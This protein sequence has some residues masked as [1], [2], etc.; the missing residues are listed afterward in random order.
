GFFGNLL[1]VG[2]ITP[3]F[4]TV[5][6]YS[7]QIAIDGD[8]SSSFVLSNGG[9]ALA[10]VT[11]VVAIT[12]AGSTDPNDTVEFSRVVTVQPGGGTFSVNVS[13]ADLNAAGIGAGLYSVAFVA[14]DAGSNSI[15]EF[16][17]NLLSIGTIAPTFTQAPTF[18]GTIDENSAFTASF[19]LGNTGN[20]PANGVSL[21][22]AITPV[23]STDPNDSKEFER[24]VTVPAGGGVFPVTIG[25]A[26]LD[27]AGI[28]AGTYTLAFVAVD[29]SGTR[30]GE[31]FGNIL[32]IGQSAVGIAQLPAYA[33]QIDQGSP[34]GATWTLTNSGSVSGDATLLTVIT[35]AGSTDPNDAV[36]FY[37]TATIPAGG[38]SVTVAITPAELA[39]A[40]I[41]AG[42]YTVAFIL[43]DAQDQR[44]GEFF[45]NLLEIF[46][47]GGSQTAV[48]F[49]AAQQAASG[50]AA[51]L[52]DAWEVSSGHP[53]EAGLA[54][55]AFIYDQAVAVFAL[56]L[57]G[58]A[59]DEA[60]ARSILQGLADLENGTGR[61]GF[62]YASG[63][64]GVEV[65]AVYSGSLAWVGYAAALYDLMTGDN[66]FR[67]M[68]IRIADQL[69]GFM[70]PTTGLI[71]GGLNENGN[72]FP[73]A[74]TEHNVD[75]YLFLSELA[76][77]TGEARFRD[78]AQTVALGILTHLWTGEHFFQGYQDDLI[79]LDAQAL[80]GLFLVMINELDDAQVVRDFIDTRF[81]RTVNVSGTPVTGYAPYQD[82]VFD[83]IWTEGSLI[84]AALDRSLGRD[85]E[86]DQITAAME[87]FRASSG[88]LNYTSAQVNANING[89]GS[90]VFPALP[91]VGA[92]GW[93]FLQDLAVTPGT[94]ALPA[95]AGSPAYTD[96]IPAGQPL[97]TT[98]EFTNNGDTP[99]ALVNLVIAVTP[100]GTDATR[101][102]GVVVPVPVGA[103][104][105]DFDVSGAA[106]SGAG[107]GEGTYTIAFIVIDR[108]GDRIGQFFGNLLTVTAPA[109]AGEGEGAAGVA[110]AP[111][112]AAV[113]TQTLPLPAAANPAGSTA[114]PVRDLF[115]VRFRTDNLSLL[116]IAPGAYRFG[117]LGGLSGFGYLYQDGFYQALADFII[118]D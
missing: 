74:S 65:S 86:A 25:N 55:R 100:V 58:E 77:L 16:F 44:I 30:L 33:A 52:L 104:S 37:R 4:T 39:A 91:H 46:S 68:A 23:G 9:N 103:A 36:E 40:N 94:G 1:E 14:L 31:F 56:L 48:E 34:F 87:N 97:F 32:E 54:D 35:P 51:G 110:P 15:G 66:T 84:V 72:P 59:A 88:G 10:S 42:D 8:F 79:V 3:T 98:W 81:E 12:P 45:G 21:V 7:D 96:T 118:E 90:V 102:F 41:G 53:L 50:P 49:L 78:A 28:G 13:H 108:H 27:A 18:S 117:L 69:I 116:N 11:L 22:V 2:T 64:Q 82:A 113:S 80:G 24:T 109:A 60:L 43:F 99:E 105:I 76:S 106:L 19:T 75:A 85:A 95:I 67:S 107:I 61:L 93:V 62:A 89:I 114:L 111:V 17:G 20:A 29:P 26:E 38:T 5:P 70:D 6:A 73:W 101:E 71:R 47:S 92:T 63:P 83:Q 112:S 115:N 57:N